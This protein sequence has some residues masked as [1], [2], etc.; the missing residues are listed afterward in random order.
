MIYLHIKINHVQIYKLRTFAD[1]FTEQR[2]V[3][4]VS[5]RH[6][7]VSARWSSCNDDRVPEPVT[8]IRC[9]E[10]SPGTRAWGCAPSC[11]RKSV[12]EGSAETLTRLDLYS[13]TPAGTEGPW[14]LARLYLTSQTRA[15]WRLW[16]AGR[17]GSVRTW[18]LWS[19]FAPR[20]SDS[21]RGS[22]CTRDSRSESN[23]RTLSAVLLWKQRTLLEISRE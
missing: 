23:W 4:C 18:C 17:R 12:R 7:G 9:A 5:W 19:P 16:T 22:S 10:T 3:H 1:V 2:V 20:W 11:A 15:R 14:D 6:W 21:E 13:G 8:S